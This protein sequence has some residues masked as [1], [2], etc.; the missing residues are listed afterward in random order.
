VGVSPQLP[1]LEKELFLRQVDVVGQTFRRL[2]DAGRSPISARYDVP[3]GHS[4][5]EVA[6]AL[7]HLYNEQLASMP[8]T[9]YYEIADSARKFTEADVMYEMLRKSEFYRSDKEN[10]GKYLAMRRNENTFWAVGVLSSFTLFLVTMVWTPRYFPTIGLTALFVLAILVITSIN[11]AHYFS[12]RL[13]RKH[14]LSAEKTLAV[15]LLD[16]YADYRPFITKTQTTPTPSVQ[17]AIQKVAS[18]LE[19]L[20]GEILTGRIRNWETIY[21]EGE[22]ASKIGRGL[23]VNVIPTLKNEKS[24]QKIGELMVRLARSMMG[25]F[26]DAIKQATD[27]L[28]QLG[29]QDASPEKPTV[30][31]SIWQGVLQIV[32]HPIFKRWIVLAAACVI[33][34]VSL[35]TVMDWQILGSSADYFGLLAALSAA[36]VAAYTSLRGKGA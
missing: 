11:F 18:K 1:L 34:Y 35:A 20:K 33:G 19:G 6:H 5:E 25:G 23:R 16:A 2:K 7:Q 29:F 21:G 3:A 26:P 22:R 14:Q 8:Q 13:W 27:V 24:S 10:V 4:G 15:G 30:F 17:N 28:T 32:T 9:G 36:Y 31:R 12:L